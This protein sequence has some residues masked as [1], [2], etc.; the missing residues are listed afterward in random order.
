MLINYR[1]I[2]TA[3]SGVLF[4]ALVGIGIVDIPQESFLAFV[5]VGFLILAG[6]FRI[7]AGRKLFSKKPINQ[8]TIKQEDVMKKLCTILIAL[9]LFLG[10]SF[11]IS[12]V[13]VSATFMWSHDVPPDIAKYTIYE[14]QDGTKQGQTFI[15]PYTYE[16]I[17]NKDFSYQVTIKDI[18][19]GVTVNKCFVIT[20]SDLTNNESADSEQVCDE[21]LIPDTE[22]PPS[23]K[24]FKFNFNE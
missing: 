14:V 3:I 10:M 13:D 20:A 7:Y 2:I 17:I 21:I 6:L 12:A 19:V 24:S 5:N 16:G 22:A 1:G 18:P 15:Y 4:N 23:C 11:P 9:L 8:P